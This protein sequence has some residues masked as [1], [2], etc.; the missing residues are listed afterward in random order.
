MFLQKEILFELLILLLHLE[1]RRGEEITV[2]SFKM[3]LLYFTSLLKAV[4]INVCMIVCGIIPP[5][6][7]PPLR[8]LCVILNRELYNLS[9]LCLAQDKNFVLLC[10]RHGVLCW[11]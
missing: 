5:Y 1:Q 6:R 3:N 9:F 11:R 10:E 2:L 7:A 8:R 4:D